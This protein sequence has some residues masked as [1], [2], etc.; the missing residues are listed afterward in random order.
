M[1]QQVY[2]DKYAQGTLTQHLRCQRQR[3]QRSGTYSRRGHLSNRISIERRPA[4][5]KC[6]TQQGDWEVD[7]MTGTGQQQALVSL[8]ERK[9]CLSLLAEVVRKRLTQ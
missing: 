2:R 7:I 4:V 3:R 6:H 5:V 1:S 8:T 9:S